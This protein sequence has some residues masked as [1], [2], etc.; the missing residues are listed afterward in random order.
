[1][2]K[3][4]AHRGA[5]AYR[6]ENTLEAFALAVEQGADGIE[7]DVHL[8][9]D[10]YIVAAHDETLERVSDGTGYI[11]NHTLSDLKKLNFNKPFPEQPAC[12]IP[13][14]D[15]VYSLLKD[16]A[17]TLNIEL[18]TNELLYPELPEKLVNMER[19]YNMGGRVI[20]SSFNHYS[21]V[22]LKKLNP[23]AKTGL[24]YSMGMIDP[25]VYAKYASADAI[26]P[27]YSVIA[28]LPET[29]AKCHESGILVNVWTIDKPDILNYM[30]ECG[31]DA[32]ITNKPDV[33]FGCREKFVFG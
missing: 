8:T 6:P 29:V 2:T 13:T 15:E 12:V 3:I 25:W 16:T 24:L 18:K 10:G 28:A 32:V 9:K 26:H 5:S 1:M 14:L 21:L 17:L 22:A 4:Q 23:D 20:Y 31:A 7:L 33:A 11:N 30:F 27:H 19:E